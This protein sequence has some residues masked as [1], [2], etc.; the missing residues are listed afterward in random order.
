MIIKFKSDQAGEF[1]M[2]G[3]VALPL[4]RMMGGSGN[5]EGAVSGELLDE[6]LQ[7]LEAAL[8]QT[9]S[10]ANETAD[11]AE[12]EKDEEE[13]QPKVGVS[14][15]ALPLLEMLRKAKAADGY[16]MWQPD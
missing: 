3:H 10:S 13:K 11:G 8:Q 14:T 7:K 5:T 9:A 16:V 2:M 1:I 6:A 4:L 12:D 15:R